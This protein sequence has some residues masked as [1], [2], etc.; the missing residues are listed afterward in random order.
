MLL[1]NDFIE[2]L[3][4]G[5]H[6]GNFVFH[7]AE[8][9]VP[10][11]AGAPV[12]AYRRS[13]QTVSRR[14]TPSKLSG[15]LFRNTKPLGLNFACFPRSSAPVHWLSFKF[16]TS[17]YSPT[18]GAPSNS[19]IFPARGA[20]EKLLGLT[21]YVVGLRAFAFAYAGCVGQPRHLS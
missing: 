2:D 6:F 16:G 17:P 14:R 3:Y 21:L 10:E 5:Y 4:P 20:P 11:R 8:G 13:P 1:F 15:T 19:T 12:P 18:W 7:T 9:R